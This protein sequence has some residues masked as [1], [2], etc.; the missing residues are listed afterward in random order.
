MHDGESRV[1]VVPWL[2][3]WATVAV[4]V[5]KNRELVEKSGV[6]G[7]SLHI[8]EPSALVPRASRAEVAANTAVNRNA[9]NASIRPI[10]N[11]DSQKSPE[12]C[13]TPHMTTPRP[14]SGDGHAS[15]NRAAGD[16]RHSEES[17]IG[18]FD[19]LAA[20]IEGLR[21]E[22]DYLK[23]QVALLHENNSKHRRR[24]GER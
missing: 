1:S 15:E 13:K 14:S 18:A 2:R 12:Y 10:P 19:L 4:F 11:S 6:D 23:E 3:D 8:V 5:H 7:G 21:R 20:Q 16:Q 24:G 22:I 9:K 17:P